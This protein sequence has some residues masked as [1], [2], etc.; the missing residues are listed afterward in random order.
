MKDSKQYAVGSRQLAVGSWYK[1][2]V[3]LLLTAYC[4]LLTVYADAFSIGAIEVKSS[5]NEAFRA[6]I[7]V[8]VDGQSGLDVSIGNEDDYAKL[9]IERIKIVDSLSLALEPVDKERVIIKLSSSKPINQPSFNLI[10][11]AVQNGGTILENYFLA[12][13][14]QKSLSLNL[15]S[16]DDKLKAEE[17]QPSIEEGIAQKPAAKLTEETKIE[18]Q[19]L[20]KTKDSEIYAPVTKE[21]IEAS[22]S[23]AGYVFTRNLKM[24]D[25]WEDVKNLQALLKLDSSIYPEGLITGYFG[26]RTKSAVIRFQKKYAS[27]ILSPLGLKS[28]TGY[29]GPFTRTKLN[30]LSDSK[31]HFIPEIPLLA[32]NLTGVDTIMQNII[33]WKKDWES[34]DIEKYISH[35]SNGFTSGGS[36]LSSWREYKS[37][38]N[39]RHDGIEISIDSIQIRK[40]K[41]LLIASFRQRFKSDKMESI[42]TKT[43]YFENDNGEWKIRNEKWNKHIEKNNQNTHPYVIHMSSFRDRE[44]ALKEVNYYRKK[45]YSAY[46]VSFKLGDKGT[47]YRVLIDRFSSKGETQEFAKAITKEGHADYAKELDLPYAIETGM[48]ES[49]EDAVKELLKLREMGYSPYPLM[50]CSSDKCSYQILIGAYGNTSNASPVSEELISKGIQN[51][52]VQP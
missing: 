46:E 41:K 26:S 39:K 51:K 23:S 8:Y 10:I 19:P 21:E 18:N 48:L 14:F 22:N 52:I 12:I 36:N 35:Y 31:T 43:L 45:G 37:N 34:K 49:H 5:L 47:W 4:L 44:S 1:N 11:K 24:G 25:R 6:E 27:E 20:A 3:F 50:I 17:I 9:G 38:F 7:P 30:T 40:E 15:P 29:V 16:A 33:D 28:G 42:G 2:W 13:D 32:E